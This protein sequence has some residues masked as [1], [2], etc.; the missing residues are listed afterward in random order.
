MP[1]YT[2]TGN[3]VVIV[4]NVPVSDFADNTIGTLDVPNN[5][6]EL[7]T[8]KNGNTIFALDEKGNNATLTLRILMSSNDDK[9]FNTLIPKSDDFASTILLNG[10]VVKQVGDGLG[11]ISFNT[12]ILTG[13]MIQKKPNISIDV[14]GD[15]NQAV[16]EYVIA[17]ANAERAII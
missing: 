1:T 17:F 4:N 5:L 15:T 2:L 3:D 14:A 11:N 9:R 10:S 8:G 13:G 12:Y 6:F 7:S 16:V